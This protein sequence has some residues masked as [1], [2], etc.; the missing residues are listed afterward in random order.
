MRIALIGAT[1]RLGGQIA[2]EA[3]ARGH[4]VTAL[5]R[6]A[7]DIFDVA[8][9]T[10][11][12]RGHDALVSAYRAPSEDTLHLLA[13]VAR[14]AIEAA[15]QAGVRRVLTVGGA[16]VLE[17]APG[18]RLGEQADFPAA[19]RPQVVAH[20]AAIDELR[21]SKGVD[22]T[23][24]VPAAR[25]APGPRSAQY[26]TA[27]GKLVQRADGSSTL[28]DADFACALIDELETGRHPRQVLGVGD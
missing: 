7:V 26:R 18:Q 5:R 19:L 2:R 6:G 22:W 28:T 11:A 14:C 10:Q 23:C 8:A 9:L 4:T 25:I 3:I 27:V 20:A 24:V 16:G 12:V 1:G 17:V 21:A 15:R 13:V